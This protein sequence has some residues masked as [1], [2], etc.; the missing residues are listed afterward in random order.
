MGAGTENMLSQI[1]VQF[2][3]QT[4]SWSLHVVD[5]GTLVELMHA[6]FRTKAVKRTGVNFPKCTIQ[7]YVG[8][9]LK[10][11]MAQCSISPYCP[12]AF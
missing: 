7:V 9:T 2:C 10:V 8:F 12:L 1:S 6:L 5:N 4:V 3:S 11:G